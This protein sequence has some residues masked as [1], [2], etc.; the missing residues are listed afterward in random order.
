MPSRRLRKATSFTMARLRSATRSLVEELAAVD[1]Q[2]LA[3]D[4]LRQRR[5]EEH[6][7][8]RDLLGRGQVLQAVLVGELVV[9]DLEVDAALLGEVVYVPLDR[10]APDVARV[11]A[12]HPDAVAAELAGE[13][14]RRHRQRR[15]RRRVG[16]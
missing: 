15:L 4:G 3:G 1:R 14:P 16:A 7:G 6:D 10:L 12:V 5:G 13:R 11:D 2:A 8:P 9:D